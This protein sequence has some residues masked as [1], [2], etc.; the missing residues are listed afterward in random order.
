MTDD[1][2]DLRDYPA[3][4]LSEA[5][6]R[7]VWQ[8]SDRRKQDPTITVAEVATQIIDLVLTLDPEDRD[9]LQREHAA[10]VAYAERRGRAAEY[11]R[12]KA[13]L[14]RVSLIHNAHGLR[15]PQS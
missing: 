3:M 8:V 10:V 1:V 9:E 15:G 11:R 6:L 12:L 7:A 5:F 2:Y 14:Q 13:E 4:P